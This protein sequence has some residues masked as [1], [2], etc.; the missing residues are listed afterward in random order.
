ML[1]PRPDSLTGQQTHSFLKADAHKDDDPPT[2][3]GTTDSAPASQENS[4]SSN[5][6]A[7]G[8][9]WDGEN[10]C[11][12]T[13]WGEGEEEEPCENGEIEESEEDFPM[14]DFNDLPEKLMEDDTLHILANFRGRGSGKT[15]STPSFLSNV[16]SVDR[17]TLLK[18]AGAEGRRVHVRVTSP[19]L[20]KV[21]RRRAKHEANAQEERQIMSRC[22]GR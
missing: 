5:D 9:W 15:S 7:G 13:A 8:E 2:D 6:F 3:G 19:P 14:Y 20:A 11:W 16:R 12:W 22:G 1:Q 18:A 10:Q 21:P 4:Q 17:R